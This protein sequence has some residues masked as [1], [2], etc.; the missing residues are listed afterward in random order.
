[1]AGNDE[2][3]APRLSWD[4]ATSTIN[5]CSLRRRTALHSVDTHK[6]TPSNFRDV[7]SLLSSQAMKVSKSHAPLSWL[8]NLRSGPSFSQVCEW[9][10]LSVRVVM[11]LAP[12]AH[13]VRQSALL[14]RIS[15][16]CHRVE[17]AEMWI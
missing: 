5:S 8:I 1:M 16:E 4:Y 13:H 3:I 12:R 6:L 15:G 17:V 11:I 14:S 9:P 10:I 7:E 2:T